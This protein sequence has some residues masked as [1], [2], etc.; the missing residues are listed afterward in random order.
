MKVLHLISEKPP[1]ISGFSR[2]ISRL[3]EELTR[4]GH[5][6]DVFSAKDCLAKTIGEIKIVISANRIANFL[7]NG[8]YDVINVHGHSPTFS[9]RFLFFSKLSKRKVVYTFHYP[10]DV[11]RPFGTLYNVLFERFF[12][13]FADAIV[14]TTESYF[15]RFRAPVK[16]YLIP[17]GVDVNMFSGERI[18]HKEY[19]LLFVGQMRPYKG[20]ETLLKAI[21]GLDATLDIVGDGPYRARYEAYA[22]KLG[23]SN[24]YFHGA[25]DDK[26]LRLLYLG[27]DVLVLPS[28]CANEAF[29]LVTL[30]AASAGC[31]VVASDLP[32]VRDVVGEFGVLVTP[33]DAYCLR[34][35]LL[36]LRDEA[37]RKEYVN[38]GFKAVTK[39]SW[40]RVAEDYVKV[41]QDV[42]STV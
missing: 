14:F 21:R 42:L 29:G 1:V 9:D 17:W 4:M 7:K 41:Y 12:S 5:V 6:V 26:V 35:A 33:D 24:V 3:K 37:V 23:L 2:V 11:F 16:K 40:R 8:G 28:V 30:E 25:V 18:P 39:Y 38:R 36:M 31:A 27:S 10:I 20:L 32:G 13:D 22:K 34:D 15:K 19:R